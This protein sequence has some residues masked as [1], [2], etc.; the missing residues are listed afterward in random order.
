[1][2]MCEL[3]VDHYKETCELL[4]EKIKDRNRFFVLLWI[5]LFLLY[6]FLI[7]RNETVS[8]IQ[9]WMKEKL[10]IDSTFSPSVFLTL[11][12]IFLLYFCM[13]YIQTNINIEREYIYVH[14]LELEIKVDGDNV[15]SRE[16][17][18]YLDKYPCVLNYIDFLYKCF[19]PILFILA[20]ALRIILEIIAHVSFVGLVVD[21][22]IAIAILILWLLH[23]A[24]IISINKYYK[25]RSNS[26]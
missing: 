11:G 21:C 25:T 13:R 18:S 12:W 22:V 15:F 23:I 4:R 17:D 14:K 24:F 16:G 10:G 5:D 2:D 20:V 9:G 1:M 26:N 3:K 19:F 6:L 7:S 8:A